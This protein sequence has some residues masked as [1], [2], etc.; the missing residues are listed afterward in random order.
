MTADGTGSFQS[1]DRA[2][3]RDV[4]TLA[5]VSVA[6][7]SNVLNHRRRRDDLIGKA[8][9][10]AAEHL[11]YRANA[12]AANLRRATS[13]LIGVVLPDFENAYFGALL[14]ALQREAATSNYRLTAA[15]S[16]DRPDLEAREVGAL[17]DWRV[18]GLIVAPTM[19]SLPDSFASTGVPIVVVDRVA[20]AMSADEVSADNAAAACEVTRQLIALGH[21][22]ILVAHSDPLALNMAER[23][24]G[25]R[26]AASELGADV[27]LDPL[28]C[29]W[30]VESADQAFEARLASGTAPTAI[31]ALNNL[32]ALAAFGAVSRCGIIPGRDI[33][34]VSFDDAT[35]MAHM[36][37]A[38]AAIAQPVDAIAHHAWSRLLARIEGEAGQVQS[39]RVPCQINPRGSMV[40]P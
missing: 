29:G 1:T 14:S 8:V 20:G 16:H 2:S 36:H 22:H 15:T 39:I 17:L 37:P 33:A 30:T 13:R 23:I 19:S 5:G 12:M 24:R 6:S 31:F 40:P 10:A 11:G 28:N 27:R 9:L 35:W 4:A 7:A 25:V 18:A 3:L 26:K 34:L 38:I 32:A 21:R